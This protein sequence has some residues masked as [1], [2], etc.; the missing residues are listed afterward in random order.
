MNVKAFEA[1]QFALQ[2]YLK[3]LKVRPAINN[4]SP[5]K[6]SVPYS[7]RNLTHMTRYEE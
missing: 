1:Q 5:K 2:H 7:S 6:Q 3:L 4:H